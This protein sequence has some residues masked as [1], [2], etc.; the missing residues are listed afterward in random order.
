MQDINWEVTVD[1]NS[2]AITTE[3][4]ADLPGKLLEQYKIDI[5]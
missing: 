5:I 4:T 1:M 2:I 3:C